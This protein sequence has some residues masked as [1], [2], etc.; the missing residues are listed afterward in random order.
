ML[1]IMYI[2]LG[3]S[4]ALPDSIVSTTDSTYAFPMYLSQGSI[5]FWGGVY[6]GVGTLAAL[7]AFWPTGRDAWG[8]ALLTAFTLLWSMF[9][10]ISSIAFDSPRGWTIGL[11]WLAFAVL[12]IIV[13][14]MRG[15]RDE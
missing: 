10:F 12:F 15:V 5:A 9:G 14:G 1:G 11:I 6:V 8:Y 3:V 2:I 13:S 4:F 7:S